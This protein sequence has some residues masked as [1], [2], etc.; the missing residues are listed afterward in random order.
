MSLINCK[1]HLEE[2]NWTKDCVL[3]SVANDNATSFKITSTK[4]CVHIVTVSTKH[5]VNL[6]KQL[7]EGFKRSIYWNEYKSKI[8][9]KVA[10]DNI[11]TR[12][13]LDA[14]FQGVNRLF[15]LAFNNVDDDANKVERNSY[16]KYV[17]PGVD[18]T[19]YT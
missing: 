7:K 18:I 16:R 12:F 8:E 6:T 11:V 3:S 5:N 17:L 9:T 13:P 10:D 1:I 4:L 15:V 2:L 19:K 14:S